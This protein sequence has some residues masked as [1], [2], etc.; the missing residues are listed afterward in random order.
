MADRVGKAY[1]WTPVG[2]SACESRRSLNCTFPNKTH[3]TRK[4]HILREIFK[5]KPGSSHAL[6]GPLMGDRHIATGSSRVR[7]TQIIVCSWII[8]RS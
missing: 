3:R 5:Q 8:V 4:I 1:C 2:R 6:E 7:S